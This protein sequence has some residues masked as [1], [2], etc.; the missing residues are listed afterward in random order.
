M[1]NQRFHL[2]MLPLGL[3]LFFLFSLSWIFLKAE[4][5]RSQHVWPHLKWMWTAKFT[6]SHTFNHDQTLDVG[7]STTL[8]E[9]IC[10]RK[11][12]DILIWFLSRCIREMALSDFYKAGLPLNGLIIMNGLIINSPFPY[13]DFR[14]IWDRDLEE[15][16]LNAECL[17]LSR[18]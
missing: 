3:F 13:G 17:N 11:A 18:F 5:K 1:L 10:L 12:N 14:R 6:H 16:N 9:Y 7:L 4:V 8:L 15:T 2:N